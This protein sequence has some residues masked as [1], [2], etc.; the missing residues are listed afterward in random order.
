MA[1]QDAAK[2]PLAEP[3]HHAVRLRGMF[4]AIFQHNNCKT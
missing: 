3:H 1:V 4:T 2:N